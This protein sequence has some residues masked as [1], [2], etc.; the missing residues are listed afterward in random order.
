MKEKKGKLLVKII[1]IAIAAMLSVSVIITVI[2][3]NIVKKTYNSLIIEELKATCEHLG[4]SVGSLNDNGDWCFENGVLLK[5]GEPIADEIE[6]IIDNLR[7]ETGIDYTIF[8]GDTRI[9]TTIHK[10]GTS[11]KLV[12]T[13][14]SDAVIASTLRQGTDFNSTSL[15]I[16]GLPYYGYYCPL[17][18]S[19]GSIVGMVFTGRESTDV[20]KAITTNALILTLIAIFS[21]LI[22]IIAGLFIAF[23]TSGKMK[24]IAD[25]INTLSS[26]NLGNKI[27]KSLE[28]RTDELGIIAENAHS[29]DK[30]LT[31]TITVVRGVSDTLAESGRD[32]NITT[33]Q[34]ATT[35]D[36]VSDAVNGIARGATEQADSIQKAVENISIL[37]DAIQT[38]ADNAEALAG[39][40]AEMG[41]ASSKS[42]ESLQDLKDNMT[43]MDEAVKEISVAMEETNGAVNKVN[44]KVDGISGIA[45]QT[46]LLA[47]NASIE[48]ARAGEQGRG[49]AVVAEEIGKLAAQS[50]QTASEIKDEMTKLLA[51]SE[52]ATNKTEEVTE[53]GRNVTAVLEETV[54]IINGLISNVAKTVDGVNNISA[55]T[56]ECN[57]SKEQIVD[58]MSS[59]S[60]ISEENAAATE[61]T[62]ASMQELNSNIGVLAESAENL[63]NLAIKLKA[64]LEF[65][66]M[67]E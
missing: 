61:E 38:V 2:S 19:N 43:K 56:E 55:L 16:E 40:A 47:L 53:I 48:A 14:A 42:A 58:A 57:A 10:T 34:I 17:K 7:V 30:Q 45:S 37:S 4:S 41:D 29:L 59:L 67:N 28:E 33:Q 6:G 22:L 60:A 24:S 39:G 63:N 36:A 1:M 51:Q 54:K 31:E 65:F 18:N 25:Y 12:G 5:G 3:I 20:K 26:G 32:L 62:S 9:L 35:T 50:G 44:E 66:K 49:F 23:K 11:E 64:D 21:M 52:G 27:D 13:K 15:N 46:N 8:Y